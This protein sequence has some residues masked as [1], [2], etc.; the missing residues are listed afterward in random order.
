MRAPANDIFTD[1]ILDGGN[2]AGVGQNIMHTTVLQMR[3]AD[4]VAVAAGGQSACQKVIEVRAQFGD[5]GVIENRYGRDVA[6]LVEVRD[7]PG[8]ECAGRGVFHR[9]KTQVAILG[10]DVGQDVEFLLGHYS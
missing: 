10:G 7:L 4:T 2:N 9:P 8:R 1:Q 5:F 3:G 6:L